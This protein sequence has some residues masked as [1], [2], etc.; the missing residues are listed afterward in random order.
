MQSLSQN[1]HVVSQSILKK[2]WYKKKNVLNINK[3]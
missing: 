3:H 1:T 2:R